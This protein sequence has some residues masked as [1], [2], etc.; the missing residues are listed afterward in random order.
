MQ[1]KGE[2][3]AIALLIVW[4]SLP[5]PTRKIRRRSNLRLNKYKQGAHRTSTLRLTHCFEAK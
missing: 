5:A 2:A 4:N 3:E 1:S